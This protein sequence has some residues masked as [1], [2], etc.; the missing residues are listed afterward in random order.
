MHAFACCRRFFSSL[1]ERFPALCLDIFILPPP[2]SRTAMACP[3]FSQTSSML[4][5]QDST[6]AGSG[7]YCGGRTQWTSQLPDALEESRKT[8]PVL[9]MIDA[10][11]RN[12]AKEEDI[13]AFFD[14]YKNAPH[15][16]SSLRIC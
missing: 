7:L 11:L 16:I 13:T 5:I 8:P 1:F 15:K 12:N 3:I 10:L 6:L 2:L 14:P 9:S 4:R